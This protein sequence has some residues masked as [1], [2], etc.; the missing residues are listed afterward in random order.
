MVLLMIALLA[1]DGRTFAM[2]RFVGNA[3]QPSLNSD[4]ERLEKL[5]P[6]EPVF[7]ELHAGLP[8]PFFDKDEFVH[9][10]WKTSNH[11][12]QG[13]RF[14]KRSE[15]PSSEVVATF[16]D[17]LADKRSFTGYAGPKMCGGY[18]ADFAVKL[19]S[20]GEAARFLVCLGCGEVLIYSN[21]LG[22]ICDLEPV[23]E[24]RLRD[25]WSEHL[26][27]PFTLVETCLP[28]PEEV[29]G[30]WGYKEYRRTHSKRPPDA[31]PRVLPG[32]VRGQTIYSGDSDSGANAPFVVFSLREE[33]FTTEEDAVGRVAELSA[34]AG[35]IA[36]GTGDNHH[37]HDCFA[38]GTRVY[39]ISTKTKSQP[40]PAHEML[41]L[42]RRHFETAST[43]E[44]KQFD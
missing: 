25:A 2:L 15:T 21:D 33:S 6:V 27:E 40:A 16:L 17:V 3:H 22:L 4:F 18:H 12:V 43:R 34:L 5:L 32:N 14:Y 38:V 36:S 10:L 13:Y 28:V 24:N 26:G 11:S 1:W 8:H 19:E 9:D 31:R 42:L 20:G 41:A 23:A 44:E 35:K 39:V 7:A 37:I 29:L 30:E